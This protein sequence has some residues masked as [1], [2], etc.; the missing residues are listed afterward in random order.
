[1]PDYS[2]DFSFLMRVLASH[3]VQFPVFSLIYSD[4]SA[5]PQCGDAHATGAKP[6]KSVDPPEDPLLK[7]VKNE[8]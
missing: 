1:M 3:I 8:I 5:R 2:G 6:K 4:S 7:K